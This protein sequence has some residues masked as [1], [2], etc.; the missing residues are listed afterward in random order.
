MARPE[1][2]H[3]VLLDAS[4]LIGLIT[5]DEQMKPL[6]TLLREV[7]AGHISI[8][9]STAIIAEVLPGHSEGDP[10][11]RDAILARLESPEVQLIDVSTVV[12]RKAAELRTTFRLKTWDAIH[13]ATAIVADV[14]VVFVRDARFPTGQT[15]EGVFVSAPFDIDDDK[16]P[17]D[18]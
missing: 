15:V 8:V 14:D 17:L 11:A 6:L 1:R 4:C 9:E 7:D 3:R 18:G 16:L 13:L 5:G 12:A 10:S 2:I